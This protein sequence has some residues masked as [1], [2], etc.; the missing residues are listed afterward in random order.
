MA[1]R[2][3]R[4][5]SWWPFVL[6]AVIVGVAAV[7]ML[8]RAQRLPSGPEPVAWDRASCAHCHMHVGDAHFAAQLQTIDGDVLNFD[9][10]GCLF[11]YERERRPATHAVYFHHSREDRWLRRD[12]AG[13][14]PAERTPMGFGFA[15]VARGT[16]G[17]ISA[18]ETARRVASRGTPG[19]SP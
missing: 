10:P 11:L 14:I 3:R 18:D 16:P 17:A 2:V 9:D 12:E 4:N 15:A 13:F 5:V 1:E 8:V 6:A 7:A 19:V